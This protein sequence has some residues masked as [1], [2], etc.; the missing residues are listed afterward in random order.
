MSYP[1]LW[2]HCM[3]SISSSWYGHLAGELL[4]RSA[5]SRLMPK[6][7]EFPNAPLAWGRTQMPKPPGDPRTKFLELGC[8]P[9]S[10][11]SQELGP[12]VSPCSGSTTKSIPG[13]TSSSD[14]SVQSGK[15]KCKCQP[16]G[17]GEKSICITRSEVIP[18]HQSPPEP[19]FHCRF[20]TDHSPSGRTRI[21]GTAAMLFSSI[22][23]TFLGRAITQHQH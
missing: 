12:R 15:R 1:K 10:R 22:P 17:A 5:H 21:M 6:S 8:L 13:E 18:V 3:L 19:P 2:F 23:I 16:S 14:W 20:V 9:G 11:D 4:L 7:T